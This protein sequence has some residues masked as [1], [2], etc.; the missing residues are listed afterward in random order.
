[1]KQSL[2]T[3]FEKN[4]ADSASNKPKSR[5]SLP[6][7]T[8]AALFGIGIAFV[9]A[10]KSSLMIHQTQIIDLR[11]HELNSLAKQRAANVADGVTAYK[12]AVLEKIAFFAQKP[13]L[14]AAFA[15]GD[16]TQLNDFSKLISKQMNDVVSVRFIP[17]GSAVLDK[18][19]FP[20]IRFSELEMIQ[21]AERREPVFPESA[22]I[23]NRWLVTFVTP[24]PADSNQ[25]VIGVMLLTLGDKPLKGIIAKQGTALG[26]T[27]LVQDFGGDKS[28]IV[29]SLGSGSVGEMRSVAVPDS[30]WRIDFHPSYALLDQVSVNSALSY[31]L[32]A[33]QFIFS[34]TLG[35][36]LGRFV[37]VRIE[38]R[39]G[40][41][42]QEGVLTSSGAGA[43]ETV[44]PSGMSTDILD[45]EITEEDE[46]LLGLGEVED[47]KAV[48]PEPVFE[49]EEVLPESDDI[50]DV[51]FRAYDI[52]GIAKEQITTSLAKHVGQ[53]LG[54]EAIDSGQDTLIVARDARLSSP[55]LTEWLIRGILST[56]CNVLNIGTV[57]TPLLYFA[58]ET[59]SESQSGV[60]VTASH[61]PGEYNGFKVVMNGKSRSAEDV[62]AI[63]ARIL[64]KQVYEGAGQ[65]HRHDIVSNYIDTIF[66][67]V[68]LAGDISI[69]IDAGNGV[70]GTVAPKLFE[71]LGCHVTP[72]FCDLDGTFPNHSPDPSKEENLSALIEKV[73]DV[74]ADLGVAFDG[75]GDRIAVVTP[76]GKIIWPDQLL[77]LF[78]KDI[79]SRNPGADVV[80]DVKS[81][82]HLNAC[83][84]SHGGRPIMWKTG[85]APMKQKMLETGALVG[86]EYSGHIFIKD[87]WYGFD[88][89]MYAAARLIEILSLQG[90]SLDM[91]FSEFETSPCT[92]EIRV[93]VV[94]E[95]KFTIIE[96]LQNEA[97][98]GDGKVTKIDGLRVDFPYGWGLVRASNTSADLTLRFEAD[99]DD[100]LHRVKSLF[101]QEIRKIDNSLTI[102]WNQ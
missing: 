54:S 40:A 69:V 23:D 16:D 76:E 102:E 41:A 71:E 61:N 52:R 37:G 89:G 58:T 77:M 21:R 86:G 29:A 17:K 64:R 12:K 83:I 79:V 9:I 28:Q 1:M 57:P 87:R 78:A 2:E 74:G 27:Q 56:G 25:P 97:E 11:F 7:R 88:D 14:S 48:S 34:M 44:A 22:R 63:R 26:N 13:T 94:E 95:K 91:I 99:D 62:K 70:T 38:T 8:R 20:P 81:T 32:I 39:L 82:R 68:A 75:D 59:L 45:I 101:V 3:T 42:E 43:S 33:V 55:E 5:K 67:D 85:H 15:A 93:P 36:F 51:V 4:K 60:M 49:E 92:P 80:F 96:R 72:L 98:F 66:S 50:P 100:A 10:L 18:S 24:L 46:D 35:F 6:I 53:A 90:E 30:Y 19:S 47:E 65:E 84:T 73:K 31:A